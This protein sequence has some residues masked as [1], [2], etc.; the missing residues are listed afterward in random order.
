MSAA[1]ARDSR[2]DAPR[3]GAPGAGRG[4][5]RARGVTVAVDGRVLV[6]AAD[7]DAAPGEVTGIIGP[8]GAGKSTLLRALAGLDRRAGGT[9]EVAG[10]DLRALR[11]PKRAALVATVP[12]ETALDFDFTVADVVAFGRHHRIGRLSRPSEEDRAAV[13]AAMRRVGVAH[14]ADRAVPTLS[15]GERQLAHI[16]RALAQDTPAM[17]LDE[18]VS[19]LDLRHELLVLSLLREVAAE[20]RAVV[21]V[22]HDLSQ[23]ARFCDRLILLGDGRVRAAGT[24][25]EVLR[26]GLLEEVYRV[27]ASVREDP[28]TGAPRVTALAA[29]PGVPGSAPDPAARRAPDDAPHHDPATPEHEGTER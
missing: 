13:A 10:R 14:L 21:A 12:Q 24:P 4:G 2:D 25:R 17:L 18:P 22:L 20:G 8:N 6:D 27:R 29:H 9:V 3:P 15:G 28:D 16:A 19:A 5:L 7:V 1:G 23:A 11:E 26:P